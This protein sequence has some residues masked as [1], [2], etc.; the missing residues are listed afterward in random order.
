M[1]LFLFGL[2]ILSCKNNEKKQ[3]EEVITIVEEV[4][5]NDQKFGEEINKECA[6]SSVEMMSSYSN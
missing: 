2:V 5:D 4:A 3:Q 1:Y 6:F